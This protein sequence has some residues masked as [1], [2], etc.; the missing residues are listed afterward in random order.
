MT[1]RRQTVIDRLVVKPGLRGKVDAMCVYCIYDPGGGG[2]TWPQQVEACTSKDCPL[3]P[4]RKVSRVA[5]K[6]V[7][8]DSN[9]TS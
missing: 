9:G 7:P 4:V 1:D 6:G 2:G 8:E 3:Y 5:G